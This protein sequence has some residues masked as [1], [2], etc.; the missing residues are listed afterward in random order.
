MR[1]LLNDGNEGAENDLDFFLEDENGNILASA[2][3]NNIGKDPYEIL[4]FSVKDGDLR[5]YFRIKRMEGDASN[6]DIKY[7]VFRGNNV[8]IKKYSAG[9][10]TIVGHPNTD[11]AIAVGALLYK[12]APIFE[13]DLRVASFSSIGGTMVNGIVLQK[14]DIVGPNGVSTT[15][16]L[17]GIDDDGDG[18]TDFFGTSAAAP[19]VGGA[20]ALLME[21]KT[22]FGVDFDINE[23]LFGTA[24]DMN[25]LGFDYLS[26]AGFIQVDSAMMTFAAPA[27]F[28]DRLVL[29]DNITPDD[30]GSVDFTV[31]IEGKNF[32]KENSF[33]TFAGEDI[34][35]EIVSSS[36]ITAEI[37]TSYFGEDMDPPLVVTTDPITQDGL[38]PDGGSATAYFS[39]LKK[40][41]VTIKAD[42]KTKLYWE[43]LPAFTAS[44]Y[45]ADEL[46]D[47]EDP[48]YFNTLNEL[49]LASDGL[50]L[51]DFTTS[52]TSR[53]IVYKYFI[54]PYFDGTF[55]P[56]LLKKYDYEFEK[57]DLIVEKLP[58]TIKA[59]DW[60]M[61][62]G[63][64]IVNDLIETE[65][66]EGISFQYLFEGNFGEGESRVLRNILNEAHLA[67]FHSE[68]YIG[69]A[70]DANILE[71][72]GRFLVN[73]AWMATDLSISNHG[74]FLVNGTP[75]IDIYANIIDSYDENDGISTISNV[76]R[77]LVNA[78][79]FI[80]ND[81]ALSNVGRFLVNE[82]GLVNGDS[83]TDEFSNLV[84]V[85]DDEDYSISSIYSIN[86]ISGLDVTP[87]DEPH[88][89]MPGAFI[90]IIAN[91]LNIT[92]EAGNLWIELAELQATADDKWII[93]GDPLP[94]FSTSVSGRAYNETS[95]II[96]SN[97]EYEPTDYNGIGHYEIIAST[98]LNYPSNYT[99]PSAN[100]QNATL[101]V[102]DYE[103]L[104]FLVSTTEGVRLVNADGSSTLLINSSNENVE[105]YNDIIYVLTSDFEIEKY[106]RQG[107]PLGS[108]TLPVE[109]SDNL[110]SG[111]YLGFVVIPNSDIALLDNRDDKIYFINSQGG[112]LNTVNILNTP[113]FIL[114]NLDGVVN[115]NH[116]I[117]SDD[118]QN[119][120][121]DVNLESYEVSI[122]RDLSNLEGWLSAVDYY[123]G[124]YYVCQARKIW[125]FKEGQVETLIA[126]FGSEE[127]NVTGIVVAGNYAYVAFNYNPNVYKVDLS[128]GEYEI[129][130][131]ELLSAQ[132][133]EVYLPI[134]L[135]DQ[136]NGK[137]AIA[138]FNDDGNTE[139]VVINSDGTNPIILFEGTD[140]VRDP[141]FS[142]D[143]NEIVFSIEASGETYNSNI[144]KINIDGSDLAQL[145][146]DN[147]SQF[148][149]FSPDG[150]KITFVQGNQITEMNLDGTD[151]ETLTSSNTGSKLW[152]T[153][154]IDGNE[155]YFTIFKN[156]NNTG[157]NDIY[158][159][160]VNTKVVTQITNATIFHRSIEVSPDGN[161]IL[162]ARAPQS[163][164]SG[165]AIETIDIDGNDLPSLI[166]Q[167]PSLLSVDDPTYSPDG[168]KIAFI[169]FDGDVDLYV[170]NVDGTGVHEIYTRGENNVLQPTW[171][172]YPDELE[173][174]STMNSESILI[175]GEI[176]IYPNPVINI[177][178]IVHEDENVTN[179]DV[180][181]VNSLTGNILFNDNLTI[182]L[183]KFEVELSWLASGIYILQINDGKTKEEFHFQKE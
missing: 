38:G 62:Y 147:Y 59:N 113:D 68:G 122:L 10:S 23:A 83:D 97:I 102:S 136:I 183:D 50:I 167:H 22:R 161:R 71:N 91:N 9:I 63:D 56:D 80:N 141:N 121:I 74:R 108:I 134:Y 14:P 40:V 165:I 58:V 158:K 13:N 89:I 78:E 16:N 128:T 24:A 181:I 174:F 151:P 170:M 65:E 19:H 46:L 120:L 153:Y 173:M 17:G 39:E 138:P 106:D 127:Y 107:Q 131:S 117:V 81:E 182:I 64:H 42:D 57:G 2:E 115:G 7:I 150:N 43:E 160:N 45:I 53:S 156:V 162:Y 48:D 112:Y 1:N 104:K 163:G 142:P 20:V 116:L 114:Q 130:A 67:T 149:E 175:Q 166:Y 139:L 29:P 4:N 66:I 73:E 49:E 119:K 164:T 146:T 103:D 11:K 34:S 69:L 93:N 21:A 98:A 85:T 55:S 37:L 82:G 88:N 54:Q 133:I 18:Y 3:D 84:M 110:N 72:V 76:G 70:T 75:I 132:D 171:G 168:Q 61:T 87:E 180:V 47:P 26:G 118:G 99:L 8:K 144:F 157:L 105:I 124:T 154:S 123:N 177:L 125:A 31:T 159:V 30:I 140:F 32:I 52:A 41:T 94:K 5:G 15:V 145:T 126:T 36:I 44:V 33:V 12:N 109:V 86:L 148:P 35:F 28:I 176:T 90:D 6:L 143:G 79:L 169:N 96:F 155:I 172:T 137:I 178:T 92:Y 95:E 27:P 111:Q 51:F 135:P 77:F 100:I 179:I 25:E 60:T 129:F 152:P 101:T